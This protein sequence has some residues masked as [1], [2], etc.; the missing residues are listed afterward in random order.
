MPREVPWRKSLQA[1]LGGVTVVL[2]AVSLLLIAGNLALLSS[3]RGHAALVNAFS[4]GRALS[5]RLLYQA[6][7]LFDESGRRRAEALADLRDAMARMD[8]R[9]LQVLEGDPGAGVPAVTD[10]RLLPDLRERHE[11]W[12][13]GIRPLLEGL[14]AAPSR[15]EAQSAL[16]S[17]DRMLVEMARE[18]DEEVTLL[19]R[20]L[21]EKD[22]RF[23]WLQYLFAGIVA[24]TVG[25]VA[26]I[27][28]SVAGRTRSLASTAE[29]IA[30]GD[31]ASSA[32]VAGGDEL[33]VLGEVFD[34]MTANLR[35]AIETEKAGR[36]RAAAGEARIRAIMDAIPDTVLTID[37]RGTV[38][39]CNAAVEA[40]FGYRPDEVL[41][42]NVSM[43]M[44]S[45]HREEHDGYIARYLRTGEAKIIGKSRE[46]EA[47]RRDGA[48][49]P[50]SL[51]VSEMR[52]GDARLF[53]GVIQDITR[54]REAEAVRERL[55]EAVIE[56]AG[57]VASATAEILAGTTQQASGA[58]EQA[59]AV[60]QTA[61]TVD[62]VLRTSDQA[63]QRAR[64]VAE[65]SQR[66]VEIGKAGRKAV[67]ETVAGMG[68]VREQVE[69]IAESILALAEQAQAI[70]E[71]IATVNDIAEQTN[72]LA[73]NAA[74]E[75]SRAGEHGRGFSVVASE[76][77]ALADQS[78]KA[79][80]QVRQIL[81]E[82]QKATNSAV[83]ATEEGTKTVS[84]AIKVVGQAGETIRALADTIAETAQA[85]AQITASAGQQAAGMAQIHEAMKSIHQV[86]NQNLASTR[87]AERA[88]QDLDALG[89]RLKELLAGYGR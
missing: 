40:R 9:F 77:K 46:L 54:R 66:T 45:P 36:E 87:Q 89:G 3:I 51:W 47:Q 15:A 2:L 22:D 14:V 42:R 29:R 72:L 10:P 44:P 62:E 21:A 55:V 65:T 74:I 49:F 69:S 58:Q 79:T 33:A 53:I 80:A 1:R 67:E 24:V 76:V 64:T 7:R 48:R 56:T 6:D 11:R 73:L 19:E 75:A 13:T 28:R 85:A 68:A 31:L 37:E 43:L 38:S 16:P 27:A 78:K 81:G 61:S 59:A 23:R 25:P 30:A 41:G 20:I 12:R 83:M 71:I 88:A 70:G 50:I 82:I 60:A 8:R 32:A 57:Q 39:A 84:A 5:Y 86:T 34:A 63:A 35:R 17:L 18:L 26:W 4:R 52:H